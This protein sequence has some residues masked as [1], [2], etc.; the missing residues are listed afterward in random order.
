MTEKHVAVKLAAS[1][2][3]LGHLP[4]AP[5]TWASAGALAVYLAVDQLPRP[6]AVVVLG[7]LLAVVIVLGLH[8]CPRAQALYGSEDP[9]PF[10]LDEVAGQWLTCLV[11]WPHDG[12]WPAAGA[13]VAFRVF[14]IVKPPPVCNAEKLPGAWGP[15]ADDLVAA[16]YAAGALWLV[17]LLPG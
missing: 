3:G 5:G 1:A 12:L 7:A 14:D 17:R 10:V 6:W 9:R 8:L 16:L 2:L 15:M 13:F 11:L 4:V